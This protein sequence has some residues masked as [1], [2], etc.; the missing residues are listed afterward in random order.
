MKNLKKSRW[1]LIILSILVLSGCIGMTVCLLFSNYQNVRLFKQAQNNFRRGDNDSLTTAE[2]Q[3]QQL[4]RNDNDHEA[5]YIMLGEIARKRK[6]YPEQV[7]FCYMAH[8]LNPLSA[9]N[10]ER[11]I[12]SLWYARYFDRLENFL[13]HQH[14][15]SDQSYQLLL[16]SAGR[17]GNLKKYKLKLSRRDNDNAVGELAFLLFEY[18][19]LTPEQKLSAL[20]NIKE[21]PLVKQELLAARAELFLTAGD[22]DNAEKALKEA[23]QLNAYAFAPALG[24][25]YANF[26]TLGQALSVF[27]K[28]LSTYHDPAIALQAAEIY[29]LLKKTDQLAE[30]RK[31]Y[32]ADSGSSAMLLCYYFD[33]L[34]AFANGNIDGTK[35][36]LVPLRKNIST[37]L[38]LYMF[39]CVDIKDK[40]LLAVI[41]N[42]TAL[43]ARNGYAELKRSADDLISSFLK[44]SLEESR[45]KEDL[46][47]PLANLLYTRK[48]EPFTAKFILLAQKKSGKINISLLKDALKRFPEDQGII[49]LAIEYCLKND[50]DGSKK[51]IERY[52]KNFPA[53]AKDM[54][55]YEIIY[56]S[57][58][59]DQ[60]LASSL[61]KKNFSPELLEEYWNFAKATMREDD[62]RFLSRDK[63]YAPFCQALLLM[64]KGNKNAACDLLE[65]ADARGN[66]PLLFFAARTLA[67]NGRNEAAI[68]KYASFPENS[69]YQLIVLLNMAEIFA[70]SGNAEKSL[71][72]AERA[73]KQA[74]DLPETQ[75]CYADKLYRNGK[76]TQI[77]DV[78]RPKSST[79][80]RKRMTSLWVSGMRQRIK[81]SDF[82][83][84]KEKTREL[85]RQ[86][87][88]IVPDDKTALECLKKLNKMPQ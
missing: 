14:D 78:V 32:Q 41:E 80:H 87:L 16:Y 10:K 28:H 85:C 52:K 46:F 40:N 54:L 27:E 57:Q 35:E 8:R 72:L 82:N 61:F 6:V 64:K 62:L 24:K 5:A 56:A 37:S 15:L 33:A 36:L 84:R 23:H 13:S 70:E 71:S 7:Y 44:N 21:T 50:L 29:C 39:L 73:Y 66:L 75:L 18:K 22:I 81:E 38:A 47:L 69:P 68:K 55:R 48:Q 43:T 42:Y 77:P 19:H 25:F 20:R 76:L 65:R 59:R 34:N 31:H 17:C 74:P 51:L 26:R 2:A 83:N 30:L 3:L 1:I 11:Y 58:K 79:P 9:E 45:G 60:N 88:S 4:I 86:L 67:E 49:K 53:K 12:E 63:V